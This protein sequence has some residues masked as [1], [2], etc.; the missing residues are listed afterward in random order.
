MMKKNA[1]LIMI[2]VAVAAAQSGVVASSSA[3]TVYNIVG[4]SALFLEA[5]EAASQPTSNGGL[6]LGCIWSESWS[7]VQ[8]SPS[9]VIATDTRGTGLPEYGNAWIAW[10][11]SA[12]SGN[13]VTCGS[14]LPSGGVVYLYL[15]VDSVVGN[16]CLFNGCTITN[17]ASGAT[18]AK[19]IY[20][21]TGTTFGT[22]VATLPSFIA[23]LFTGSNAT[24]NIAAT[25]IRPEDAEFATKRALYACGQPFEGQY[26][27]LGYADPTSIKSYWSGV[28]FN[29]GHFT[30]PSSYSV[31]TVGADPILVVVNE[32]DGN[33]FANT[34]IQNITS[35]TL[36]EILDGTFSET[37]DVSGIT[38]NN[39]PITVVER[40]PASGTYNTMEFNVP[41]TLENQTSQDVG[42]LQQPGQQN[43]SGTSFGSN[44]M[45][46]V[47]TDG[48]GVRT[49][50]IGTGELLNVIFGG[51][52]AGASGTY[53]SGAPA[54]L[55]YGFWSVGN[56]KGAYTGSANYKTHARYLTVD[57]IDPL[58]NSAGAY[59]PL[60]GAANQCAGGTCPAG[61]IPTGSS[62]SDG[63]NGGIT[64][65]TLAN[66]QNGS[67]PIWSFLRLVCTTAC[68]GASNLA[69][70]TQSNLGFGASASPSTPPDFVPTAATGALAVHNSTVVR[71]HF[72][73]PG[74]GGLHCTVSNGLAAGGELTECGGDVGGVVYTQV[75]DEDFDANTFSETGITG[76]RR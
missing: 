31:Y 16:R 67:Y 49:R 4:S 54:L 13:T 35:G 48:Y 20:S 29:V 45:N 5:G 11:P 65:V 63:G 22:E 46:I 27:G 38:T 47:T 61:T 9:S 39:E 73:P 44:P 41:N 12:I 25:D 50:A 60:S 56:F 2:A 15:S 23:S 75:G 72:L 33:G 53:F 43:C 36:A 32:P 74:I 18:T 1:F 62:A 55:G 70:A 17:N 40:E 37:Q 26:L 21:S 34:A 66:V 14:S 10:T 57:G 68:T 8:T 30:L 52:V 7:G 69:T 24:V 42:L 76:N 71:S 51:S 19:K 6:N 59:T 3:Q 58:F 28:L 64:A